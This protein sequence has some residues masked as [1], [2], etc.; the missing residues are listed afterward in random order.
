MTIHGPP[1]APGPA[2]L[3]TEGANEAASSGHEGG[4]ALLTNTRFPM[5]E[6]EQTGPAP[7]GAGFTGDSHPG[8]TAHR[9]NNKI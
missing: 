1:A 3:K 6:V 8:V 4:S 5:L 7:S 2:G 9:R